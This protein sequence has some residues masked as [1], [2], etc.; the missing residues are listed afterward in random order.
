MVISNPFRVVFG[1]RELFKSDFS[2]STW[3]IQQLSSLKK[4]YI[5]KMIRLDFIRASKHSKCL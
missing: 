3:P 4:E 1:N 5:T 2:K